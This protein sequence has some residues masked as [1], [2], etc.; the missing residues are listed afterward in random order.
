M[1]FFAP[2][3]VPGP[4]R[5]Y[6]AGVQGP[7]KHLRAKTGSLTKSLHKS[8]LQPTSLAISSQYEM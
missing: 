5:R 8:G 1:A 4:I 6:C 3:H 7:K 2:T